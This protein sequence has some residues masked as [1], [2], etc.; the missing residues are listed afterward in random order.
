[1]PQCQPV[2]F[3]FS[4][5]NNCLCI[6]M[7]THFKAEIPSSC[8]RKPHQ[9]PESINSEDQTFIFSAFEPLGITSSKSSPPLKKIRYLLSKQSLG[10]SPNH[11]TP[12]NEILGFFFTVTYSN[13]EL[14][15]LSIG[16]DKEWTGSLMFRTVPEDRSK[17]GI[18]MLS[19][20][21]YQFH[22]LTVF[23]KLKAFSYSRLFCTREPRLG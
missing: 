3:F 4:Q 12:E 2:F 8:H 10:I 22:I 18:T 16:K 11:T 23:H 6:I 17:I 20:E 1:M 9:I 7:V 5:Q 14:A 19:Q 21:P 15:K 13:T